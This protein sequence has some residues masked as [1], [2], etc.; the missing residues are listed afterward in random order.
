MRN[1]STEVSVLVKATFSMNHLPFLYICSLQRKKSNINI[2][3][4]II[5]NHPGRVIQRLSQSNQTR[6]TS[7]GYIHVNKPFTCKMKCFTF[8]PRGFV[9]FS[10]VGLRSLLILLNLEYILQ[11]GTLLTHLKWARFSFRLVVY[12][13]S[14]F[15]D[16]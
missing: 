14:P 12:L 9:S 5:L 16:I 11:S 10:V 2:S 7:L 15:Q 6:L 8:Y 13:A 1:M 3:S 4:V